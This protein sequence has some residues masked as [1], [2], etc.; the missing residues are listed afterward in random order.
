M[1]QEFYEDGSPSRTVVDD[2]DPWQDVRR[3]L[4]SVINRHSLENF[5]ENTPDF[6]VA[7]Y[8]ILCLQ[9]LKNA[10]VARDRFHG[11]DSGATFRHQPTE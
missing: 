2:Q 7:D 11:F 5:V 3:D 10:N 8:L 4:A 9:A 1:A 6:A